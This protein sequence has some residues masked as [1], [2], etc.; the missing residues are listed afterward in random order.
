VPV[1]RGLGQPGSGHGDGHPRHGVATVRAVAVLGAGVVRLETGDGDGR[2]V[3]YLP[4]GMRPTLLSLTPTDGTV[5]PAPDQPRWLVYG[6]SVAEGWVASGP[7]GAW[8]S[9]AGRSY[10]LDVV[11]CGYAG[12]ARGEIASAEQLARVAADVIAVCHGTNC[13]SRTPHSVAMMAAGTDAFLTVL[14]QGHPATPIVVLSPVLRPDAEGT[15]NRLGATLADLRDAV[16]QVVEAR[17]DVTLVRG[18]PLLDASMLP[19]GIH[20]GDEGHRLLAAAVGPVVE[21][22]LGSG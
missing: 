9:V 17:A 14:R 3:V 22:L 8:P 11:N 19:D 6:D 18:L 15:A 16:E 21:G 1:G 12:S 10:G 20:P 13:W 5:S 4:E 7:S 2:C